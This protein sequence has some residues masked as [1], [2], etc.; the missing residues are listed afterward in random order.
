MGKILAARPRGSGEGDCIPLATPLDLTA[1]QWDMAR[2]SVDVW[3]CEYPNC[4]HAWI[5]QTNEP[6][7]RCA[8]CKTC[9]WHKTPSP[10][11]I[12][13]KNNWLD[14]L[15]DAVKPFVKEQ[16]AQA[17]LDAKA[18]KGEYVAEAIPLPAAAMLPSTKCGYRREDY[19]T[20]YAGYCGKIAGHK[21]DHGLWQRGEPLNP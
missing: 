13:R 17:I 8:K 12:I 6:P 18:R 15:L 5:A 16:I 19:E 9:N 20:G 21:L 3:V 10:V 11:E 14:Q 7:R 4:R 2:Q 1:I